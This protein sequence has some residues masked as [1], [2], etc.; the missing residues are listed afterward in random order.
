MGSHLDDIYAR[1]VT[2][3]TVRPERRIQENNFIGIPQSESWMDN[4]RRYLEVGSLPDNKDEARKIEKMSGR[5]FLKGGY[6]FK[7]SFATLALRCL[8]P[9]EAWEV[10]KEIHEGSCGNHAGGQSLATKIL[11]S[12]YFWPTMQQDSMQIVRKCVR[13]QVHGN[14]H[15]APAVGIEFTCPAWPFDHWGMDIIGHFPQA[16]GQRK[17]I[18]V[19]VDHFTK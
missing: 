2:I 9:K 3:L 16:A 7:K 18:L 11:R 8:N 6:L 14:L 19:A 15:H 4:I 12:G 10:M 13:C 5:F 1:R 17:F